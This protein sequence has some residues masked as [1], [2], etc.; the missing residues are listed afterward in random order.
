MSLSIPITADA[1]TLSDA[2]RT[3]HVAQSSMELLPNYYRWTYGAF[4]PHL[5]GD[6]VELGC[7]AGLGI[8]TYLQA[9]R[10]VTA[11]DHDPAL[12]RRISTVHPPSC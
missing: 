4:L 12:L 3:Y 9:A 5:T 6:V 10:S 2:N 11:V 8:G 1:S 7:G